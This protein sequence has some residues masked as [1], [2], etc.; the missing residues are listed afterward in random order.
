MEKRVTGYANTIQ[1][2]CLATSYQNKISTTLRYVE[3]TGCA[4]FV[5][6]KFH[7]LLFILF[8]YVSFLLVVFIP[9]F[10]PIFLNMTNILNVQE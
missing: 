2:L 9:L 8:S 6:L 1:L 5:I 7:F 10:K 4:K 3:E